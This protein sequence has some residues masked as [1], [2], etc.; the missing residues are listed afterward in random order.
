LNNISFENF[1]IQYFLFPKTIGAERLKNYNL[2]FNNLIADFKFIYIFLLPIFY[3]IG[4]K[5]IKNKNLKKDEIFF[6]NILFVF[7]IF[8]IIFHQIITKNQIF[9]FFIIPIIFSFTFL[10]LKKNFIKSKYYL[11]TMILLMIFITMKYHHRFNED[12]K[13]MELSKINKVNYVNA[14]E[15]S[16][17]LR[18]LKWITKKYSL[19]PHKEAELLRKSISFLEKE[20][21]N[22]ILITEY[23]F[24]SSN[25]EKN[26]FSFNRWYTTD[27]VS[28][29][30]KGNKYRKNYKKFYNKQIIKNNIK[31]IYTIKPKNIKNIKF[32]FDKDCIKTNQ[33]NQILYEHNLKNCVIN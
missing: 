17:N 30:L 11:I 26:I 15:I 32:I 2:N 19:N 20:K 1:L 12:R 9:I 25:L 6:Y 27:G 10:V 18:G 24:I 28:Y 22:L 5:F 14:S 31:L 3:S 13:F 4:I 29:P 8:T 23:Q 21:R 7:F 33:I 16:E